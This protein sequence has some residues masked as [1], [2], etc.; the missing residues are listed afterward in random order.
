MSQVLPKTNHPA[1][2]DSRQWTG[3]LPPPALAEHR[4]QPRSLESEASVER[5]WS[6]VATLGFV[7]SVGVWF[8]CFLRLRALQ[9]AVWQVD[10]PLGWGFWSVVIGTFGLAV[11]TFNSKMKW[12]RRTGRYA[13]AGATL[14]LFSI[15]PLALVFAAER[16]HAVPI[17]AERWIITE[18]NGGCGRRGFRWR[19]ESYYQGFTAYDANGLAFS[20]NRYGNRWRYHCAYGQLVESPWGLRWFALKE[21]ERVE[22]DDARDLE[23]RR[24]V[25]QKCVSRLNPTNGKRKVP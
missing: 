7:L 18:R 5:D 25:V 24:A 20:G 13:L 17:E 15:I 3:E 23:S 2:I 21:V 14:V 9:P 19:C 8:S 10:T 6:K 1:V 11:F 4:F 22:F 16:R 12:G